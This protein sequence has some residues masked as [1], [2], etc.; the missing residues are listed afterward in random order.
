MFQQKKQTKNE[1]NTERFCIKLLSLRA[2]GGH[3][4]QWRQRQQ[5]RR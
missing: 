5:R 3:M 2:F 4:R 1:F